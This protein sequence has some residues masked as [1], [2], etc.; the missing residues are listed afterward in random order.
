MNRI[1]IL[2]DTVLRPG[3]RALRQQAGPVEVS[4][5]STLERASPLSRPE[6]VIRPGYEQGRAEGYAAGLEKGLADA[7]ARI[8]EEM[9]TRQRR[10]AAQF[11]QAEAR[12]ATDQARQ[13][14]VLDALIQALEKAAFVQAP[15]L[16]R[17]AIA[18]ALEA[19]CKLA[20]P[21]AGRQQ[22]LVDLVKKALTQLRGNALLTI[23]MHP[24]DLAELTSTADGRA[25]VEQR[26]SAQWAADPSL[27]RGA[28]LLDS[29]H[30]RLDA[31]LHTQLDRLRELWAEAGEGAAE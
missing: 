26:A 12:L 24:A 9:D 15:A 23:R 27:E 8:A 21:N 5:S 17:Q 14:A 31:G 30:G 29:D 10:L 19:L 13:F 11:S 20:E 7:T 25:L 6:L 2:R 18:L 28:C 22:L 16:E 4:Q 3:R 1:S